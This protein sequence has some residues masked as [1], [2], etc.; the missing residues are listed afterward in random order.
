M[1]SIKKLAAAAL[2]MVTATVLA[3]CMAVSRPEGWTEST[4]GKDAPP[5]YDVVLAQDEVK[6]LDIVI[7]P[8]DWQAMLADMTER[9]GPFGEGGG[10]DIPQE[11]IDACE[12]LVEGDL[13]VV[14]IDGTDTEGE[15]GSVFGTTVCIP[16]GFG[17]GGGGGGRPG[18]SGDPAAGTGEDG[19]DLVDG[20]PIWVPCS[21][22]FEGARWW[23][24]GI[25]FKGNSTLSST[26]QG[27]S[28]K[29]PFKLDF[30]QLEEAYPEIE[31]QRFFG[32]QK[33]A[34]ANNELDASYLRDKVA[35][36]LFREAGVPA[37]RRA[38]IRVFF[39][40]GEGPVYFGLYTMA[41][42]PDRPMFL[43]QL[44]ATG[45]NLY[46]PVMGAAD[47]VQGLPI[48]EQW[49]AKKSSG[50]DWS[51]VRAAVAA[52]HASRSDADAWRAGLEQRF[53]VDGFLHWLAINTT[54]QDWDTYGNMAHN[55]YLYG[56]PSDGGRLRWIP[57]DHN[58]SLSSSLGLAPPLPL[59][60]SGVTEDWPLIR[61]LYDDPIYQQRYWSYVEALTEGV[62]SEDAMSERLGAEHALIA[63]FVAGPEG[64]QPQH[65]IVMGSPE[66]FDASLAELTGHVQQRHEAVAAALSARR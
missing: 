4:H 10:L 18:G 21:V 15:C 7:D 9:V 65:T 55:Y 2:S 28:Y 24:V 51:D 20:D 1:T 31:D 49:F 35:G 19:T 30:D 17:P 33:L 52:L 40:V 39:D 11:A 6:R 47:W 23:H 46:K 56:D 34:F 37:P 61:Y 63:P 53:D 44:G 5:A 54:I 60:M 45:G 12:G 32:F 22:D 8:D 66:A 27:G 41:E 58:M 62:F 38:F 36:D 43:T 48:D 50:G 42:V 3:S 14:P 59:D 13:C 16:P 26:W 64:E 57:W 29:L 25:R